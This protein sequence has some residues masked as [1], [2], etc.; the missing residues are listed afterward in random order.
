[1]ILENANTIH[2]NMKDYDGY[3]SYIAICGVGKQ[4]INYY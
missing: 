2:M 4:V 1:M 3:T